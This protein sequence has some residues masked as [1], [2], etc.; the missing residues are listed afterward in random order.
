MII[1]ET[2]LAVGGYR[3]AMTYVLR[4][5]PSAPVIDASLLKSLHFMMIKHDLD[6]NPGEYRPGA[7]WVEDGDGA[8][9]YEAPD[10]ELVGLLVDR[11]LQ[12]IAESQQPAMVTAAMAHL[13]LTLIHPFSDG[14]GRMARCLQTFILGTGSVM[15]PVFVSIEEYLGRNTRD[16]YDVLSEVA[17]GRWSPERSARPWIEFCLTAHYHQARLLLVRVRESE[18]LWDACSQLVSRHRLPDRTSDA[19]V[20]S[21]RGWKIWRSLYIKITEAARGEAMTEATATRDLAALTAAGLLAPVGE[22]RGRYYEPAAELRTTWQE[23]RCLRRPLRNF[24]P[25]G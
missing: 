18:A 14:N 7:V 19:L 9:I 20:L 16:Y 25:Y 10:Q 5:V 23:I 24:N 22:K 12:E 13:N 8:V 6:K 15:E 3:D 21:A 1:E 4:L 11:L 17:R 2:R